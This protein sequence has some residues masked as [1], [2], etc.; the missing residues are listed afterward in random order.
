M[1]MMLNS[2]FPQLR[3]LEL[4]MVNDGRLAARTVS[5]QVIMVS[6]LVCSQCQEV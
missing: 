5:D 6:A 2:V 1:I 4:A 3:N